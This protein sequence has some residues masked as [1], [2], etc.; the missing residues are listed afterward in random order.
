MGYPLAAQAL[1]NRAEVLR[2]G[3]WPNDGQPPQ[4]PQPPPQFPDGNDN[5]PPAWTWPQ[6]DQPPVQQTSGV[7]GDSS[8]MPM[9]ALL[10]AGLAFT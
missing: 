2:S 3:T 8:L 4:F 7:D 9:L 10:G 6:V 1:R 5:D